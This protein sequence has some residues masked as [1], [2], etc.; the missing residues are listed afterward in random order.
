MRAAHS[1]RKAHHGQG[2]L[3]YERHRPE[4]TLLYQLVEQHYPCLLATVADSE[5][6]L[7]KYVRQEFEDYLKCGRLEY[8]FLRLRCEACHAEKLL[9]FASH[10]DFHIGD[11]I[12]QR[13]I[14]AH[15]FLRSRIESLAIDLDVGGQ[16]FNA[17]QDNFSFGRDDLDVIGED[18][19]IQLRLGGVMRRFVNHH[20]ILDRRTVGEVR[21]QFIVRVFAERWHCET[22]LCS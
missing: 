1:A 11:E 22:N 18:L 8:G 5:Q 12:A 14:G 17:V 19:A 16:R 3:R 2:E 9:A 13:T 15:A 20:Q 21:Q 6:S 7:P 4:Q 10:R